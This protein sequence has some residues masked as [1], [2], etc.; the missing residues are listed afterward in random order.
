[1]LVLDKV[2]TCSYIEGVANLRTVGIKDLKN[3]LSAYLREVR[4]GTR[5]LVSDR[6]AVVAELHEPGASYPLAGAADP[7]MAR[8]IEA[9]VVVPASRPKQTLPRSP[10]TLDEGAARRLLDEDR[11]EGSG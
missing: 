8:W 4:L 3:N 10:V 5:I 2:A 6:S 7:I 9:G 1:M 11:A